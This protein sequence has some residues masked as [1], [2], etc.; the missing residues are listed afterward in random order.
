[1]SKHSLHETI[2]TVGILVIGILFLYV[3]LGLS[4]IGFQP[5]NLIQPSKWKKSEDKNNMLQIIP[6]YNA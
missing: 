4:S 3:G 1:M 6:A 5:K 2:D